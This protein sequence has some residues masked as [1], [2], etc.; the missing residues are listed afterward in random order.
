ML[1]AIDSAFP[2]DP[3]NHDFKKTTQKQLGKTQ[4]VSKMDGG[5]SITFLC[6]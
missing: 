3:K 1:F 5:K 2:N 4:T 6:I